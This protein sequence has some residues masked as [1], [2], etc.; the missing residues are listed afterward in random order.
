MAQ[1]PRPPPKYSKLDRTSAAP[2]GAESPFLTPATGVSR[3]S[4]AGRAD[5]SP[6]LSLDAAV[7]SGATSS[8]E[9]SGFVSDDPNIGQVFGGKYVIERLLGEGGMGIVYLARH[10]A[11]GK[12]FAIKLLHPEAVKDPE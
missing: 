1:P 12:K 6:R 4:E 3:P 5:T 11:I 7:L 10:K 2:P 9:P 8:V